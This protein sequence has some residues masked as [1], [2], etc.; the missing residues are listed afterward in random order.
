MAIAVLSEEL[1]D[2]LIRLYLAAG[3]SRR[4]ARTV[5]V[6]Q[7]EADLRGVVGHGSRL[8]PGYVAKL[9]SGHLTARPKMT[10]RSAGAG[11]LVLDADR[12]PGALAVKHAVS[13]A[14]T[15]ARCQGVALVIVRNAGHAGALG[16][17][18]AQLGRRG[19]VG[20]LAAQT[21]G[22]SVA[23]LGGP[24]TG[25]LG[26][27]ALAVAVPGPDPHRPVLLDMAA[28]SM[29]WGRLHEHARTGR[30]LP[31]GCALDQGGQPTR[32]PERAAVLL[33]SGERAQA[34]VIVLELLVGALTGSP[35][36]PC[37]DE[38][39]GLLCLA[40]DPARLGTGGQL[41]AAV[42]EVAL[43]LGEHGARLPGQRAWS[44]HDHAAARGIRLAEP[45][46]AALIAAGDPHVPPPPAWTTRHNDNST[47]VLL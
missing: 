5:A 24:G 10:R 19:L 40:I 18:A 6:A 11:C 8:A 44:H 3:M 2:Y 31:E 39:R 23:V 25:L 16:V 32:D 4:G 14:A 28:G 1:T 7:V 46:L 26:N 29:S 43:A 12:A 17:G 15:G 36:L 45:D 30:Q 22:P 20:V 47:E 34:L 35:A 38:G 9:R 42:A 41:A 21:S 33:P 27:S 37:G 13:F